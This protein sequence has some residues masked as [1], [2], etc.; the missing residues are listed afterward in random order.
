MKSILRS[1]L[2]CAL[3]LTFNPIASAGIPAYLVWEGGKWVFREVISPGVGTYISF[4]VEN[5]LEARK[6]ED[7]ANKA[8][9]ELKSQG[10]TITHQSP[11]GTV[12]SLRSCRLS[13]D[14]LISDIAIKTGA[15]GEYRTVVQDVVNIRYPEV[16]G[17]EPSPGELPACPGGNNANEGYWIPGS[18]GGYVWQRCV[19]IKRTDHY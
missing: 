1:A 16:C 14:E 3:L 5:F 8:E 15:L 2:F 7:I 10:M 4:T 17:S 12:N 6:L 18:A 19:N 13:R 9:N 11:D